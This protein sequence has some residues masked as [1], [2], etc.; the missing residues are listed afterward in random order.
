MIIL[1]T[2]LEL[3]SLIPSDIVNFLIVL[4]AVVAIATLLYTAYQVNLDFK[5]RRGQFWLQLE[6]MFSRHDEVHLNLRPGGK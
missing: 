6:E 3:G 1:A 4:G 5:T 2:T